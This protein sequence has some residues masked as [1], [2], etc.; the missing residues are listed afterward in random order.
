MKGEHNILAYGFTKEKEGFMEIVDNLEDVIWV[1]DG[2]F[3]SS[4]IGMTGIDM[5]LGVVADLV[6][7]DLA[8]H[9]AGQI[10]YTQWDANDERVFQ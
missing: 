8:Y 10:G 6:D 5:A 4:S 2:K 7:I 9:I 1:A 3:Y